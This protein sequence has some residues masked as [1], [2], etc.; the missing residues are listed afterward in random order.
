MWNYVHT[1]ELY[2]HGIK[3][4]KWGVRRFQKEDGSLTA[5]GKQRYSDEDR[6][7]EKAARKQARDERR[8]SAKTGA[9]TATKVGLAIG[10][11][12]LIGAGALIANRWQED[13]GGGSLIEFGEKFDKTGFGAAAATRA[14]IVAASTALAAIGTTIVV[15][16]AKAAKA[17]EQEKTDKRNK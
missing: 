10:I 13:T 12:T 14:G 6:E 2:H 11:P 8:E 16:K 1:D 9:K 4:Q 17:A 7:A 15:K 5:K 3:G